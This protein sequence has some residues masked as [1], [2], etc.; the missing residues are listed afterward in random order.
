M[1]FAGSARAAL[2]LNAFGLAYGASGSSRDLSSATSATVPVH[3]LSSSHAHGIQLPVSKSIGAAPGH[4]ASTC[5]VQATVAAAPAGSK[6]AA[7]DEGRVYNFAAG[8]A[9][10]PYNVLKEAQADLINWKVGPVCWF[11]Q[12]GSGFAENKSIL[13]HHLLPRS[14]SLFQT[15]LADGQK[16]CL[17]YPGC[18]E[19][20]IERSNQASN[21]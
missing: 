6:A 15:R 19:S 12:P 10:L 16:I 4:H 7:Q 21:S 8:P 11:D 20:D 13:R 14:I 1:A 5:T 3:R 2:S 17:A 9:C 18:M